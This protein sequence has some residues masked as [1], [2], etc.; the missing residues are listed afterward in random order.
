MVVGESLAREV[1]TG[2]GQADAMA[3]FTAGRITG[4]RRTRM[5]KLVVEAQKGLDDLAATEPPW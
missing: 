2:T 5:A 3:A 4:E 1:A